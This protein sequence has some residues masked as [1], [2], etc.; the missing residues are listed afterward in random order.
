MKLYF[1]EKDGKKR[2][3]G[4]YASS[5][6]EAKKKAKRPP[7]PGVRVYKVLDKKPPKGGGWDRTRADGKS[8]GASRLGKGRG[9]GPRR[10]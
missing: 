1:L 5:A 8:P 7:G 6:A 4:V 10:T 3:T 2:N 9:Y